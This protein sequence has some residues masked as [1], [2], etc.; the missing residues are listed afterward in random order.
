MEST[1]NMILSG[2]EIWSVSG[3]TSGSFELPE[4]IVVASTKYFEFDRRYKTQINFSNPSPQTNLSGLPLQFDLSQFS[5]TTSGSILFSPFWI[6]VQSAG[7]DLIVT[8][9][10]NI[11]LPL[12]VSA[13][14]ISTRTGTIKFL[15]NTLTS[16][17]SINSY[18]LYWG[19]SIPSVVSGYSQTS[20]NSNS[21]AITKPELTDLSGSV[22]VSPDSSTTYTLEIINCCGEVIT[23]VNVIISSEVSINTIREILRGVEEGILR[24]VM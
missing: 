1:K 9:S 6:N 23:T 15:D 11:I 21:W 3:T 4:N 16:A 14:N 12:E 17:N 7:Q 10:A 5:G 8:N 18:W 2:T 20:G 13:I 22:V 24:G 19:T